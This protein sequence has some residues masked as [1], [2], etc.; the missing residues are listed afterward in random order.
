MLNFPQAHES[1]QDPNIGGYSP[2]NPETG[3]LL[4]LFN[5]KGI[6]VQT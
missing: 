2:Q 3:S 5:L 4:L 1:Q 6:D